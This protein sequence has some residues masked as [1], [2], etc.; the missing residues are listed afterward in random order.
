MRKTIISSILFA[1][2]FSSSTLV[3][4]VDTLRDMSYLPLAVGNKW[5]YIV[6]DYV[7]PYPHPSYYHTISVRGDTLLPNGRRYFILNSLLGLSENYLRIDSTMFK[8][9]KYF[10]SPTC[11]DSEIV[12]FDLLPP[13][14]GY[15][16]TCEGSVVSVDTGYARIGVLADST[17][18]I[19]YS[20]YYVL[21]YY[22]ILSR[23]IGI[24]IGMRGNCQDFK[25]T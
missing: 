14:S 24:C 25:V 12:Y 8:V 1:I 5:Q 23:G 7:S 10:E 3:G 18:Y 11:V 16:M 15:Y 21:E 2:A 22:H 17:K 6:S 13:D 9:Y 20:W 4:Q 19:S